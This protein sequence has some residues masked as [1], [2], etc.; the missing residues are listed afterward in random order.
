MAN[1]I[2]G[3]ARNVVVSQRRIDTFLRGE[4][5]KILPD[6]TSKKYKIKHV[7]YSVVDKFL[8]SFGMHVYEL[9]HPR[10]IEQYRAHSVVE[11]DD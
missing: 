5:I 1:S 6:G 2:S 7:R 3:V 9:Y 4:Y 11:R 10:L 8:V